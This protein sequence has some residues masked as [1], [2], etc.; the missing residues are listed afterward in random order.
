MAV[1]SDPPESAN[2][3]GDA[4]PLLD[5]VHE[6]GEL[7]VVSKDAVLF[8]EGEPCRGAYFVEDGE[9]ELTVT[10][11][12]RRV[13]VGIARPGQML[14]VASVCSNYDH[15]CTARAV[16]SSKV[17]FLEAESLRKYLRRDPA[18]CLVAVQLLASDLLDLSSNA[19]R[20]MRL[21]PRFR[22]N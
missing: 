2:G 9:V 6:A 22:P 21:Q 8:H 7:V 18:T 15:Q 1:M 12:E 13:K 17:V 10:S 4:K 16:R 20:P 5:Y 14:A 11:G 19:I 3:F